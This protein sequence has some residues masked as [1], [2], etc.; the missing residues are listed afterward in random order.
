MQIQRTLHFQD[1]QP[2]EA[3]DE[4]FQTA[5]DV[6]MNYAAYK[7]HLESL[8]IVNIK[9]LQDATD[10]AQLLMGMTFLVHGDEMGIEKILKLDIIPRI[11]EGTEWATIEN[12]LKQRIKALNLFI[13]DI[14]HDQ[15]VVKD[16]VIDLQMIKSCPAYLPSCHGLEPP[17]GIWTH[18]SGVDIIRDSEGNFCV[19]EDNLRT[20]SG[21][22][23]M[24][25]NRK[26]LKATFPKFFDKIMIQPVSDYP[27][28]LYQMLEYISPVSDP[29]IV[30]LTPGIYNSAYYEHSYLAQEMG[31]EL[32]EGRDLVVR[33]EYVYMRNTKGFQRVDVIYRRIDDTFL[34]PR[35][36]NPESMLG[37]EG[38]FEVYKNGKVAIA[39]APG[40]GVGDDK[41]ICPY[42]PDL[43]KYYL[44]EEPILSNVKTY[45]CSR[46]EDLE[47]VLD[48][49]EN[50]VVKET[51]AAGGYGMML[52]PKSDAEMHALFREKVRKNPRN[53]V[54]QPM[55]QLSTV[56][57][58]ADEKF[59]PRHV[60]LRPFIIY[61]EDISVI[62][63]GL[64]R[65][66]LK[67]GSLV[68]NSS[69]GGGTKD[70]W[71]CQ[72]NSNQ[73]QSC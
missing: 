32:V 24:L 4:M 31:V 6:R 11:I 15:K 2:G 53:Y 72:N 59:S 12:G 14:Y 48:N 41:A 40:T 34:D 25:E 36:F 63:G 29:T 33:G 39:N 68:V 51:N 61:G 56:P 49:I 8:S 35:E 21:V 69:Q 26:I 66:A 43:V 44:G 20:P 19:L 16:G 62:P 27:K 52:G 54:A 60:D 30:V 64:T 23:Y 38:L 5:K 7:E 18:I 47:Y 46:K 45:I 70:T 58:L 67:E 55:I 13:H 3:Y 9:K 22:S 1:Y 28:I 17:K 50:L 10:Q 37:V 71:V 42:V 73:S 57:C 65:V